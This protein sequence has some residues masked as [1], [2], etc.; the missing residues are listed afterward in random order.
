MEVAGGGMQTM[1]AEVPFA[2]VTTYS[3]TLASMTGGQGSYGIEFDRY[4]IVHG[5]IQQQVIAAAKM[6]EEED[7]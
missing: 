5:N 3:R 7:E 4:D 2:E 6:V 1:R